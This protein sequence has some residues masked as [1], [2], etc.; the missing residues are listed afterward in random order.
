MNLSL[1][2]RKLMKITDLLMSFLNTV[3]QLLHGTSLVAT[4]EDDS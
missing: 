4:I 1:Y 2:V 3:F